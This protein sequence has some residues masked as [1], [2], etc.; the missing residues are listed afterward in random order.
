[1][2]CSNCAKNRAAMAAAKQR[3][4]TTTSQQR[5]QIRQVQQTR[6]PDG[7][8]GLPVKKLNPQGTRNR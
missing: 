1:M 8:V 2:A 3:A 5:A 7:S 4:Q 6:Q